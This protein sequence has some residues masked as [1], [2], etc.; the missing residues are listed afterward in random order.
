MRLGALFLGGWSLLLASCSGGGKPGAGGDAGTVTTGGAGT[1]GGASQG[2]ASQ[3]GESQGGMG[4][5]SGGSAGDGGTAGSGGGNV[6]GTVTGVVKTELGSWNEN[7][8]IAIGAA[9]TYTDAD[10]RFEIPDVPPEYDLVLIVPT[11]SYALVIRGIS[12][13]TLHLTAPGYENGHVANLAGVAT[14]GVGTPIPDDCYAR[15][16]FQDPDNRSA[17]LFGPYGLLAASDASYAM[18]LHWVGASSV[19]GRLYALQNRVDAE[20]RPISFDGFGWTPLEVSRG[21]MY[22]KR[23]GS[24]PATTIALEPVASRTVSGTVTVPPGFAPRLDFSIGPFDLHPTFRIDEEDETRGTYSVLLPTGIEALPLSAH[25]GGV[26]MDLD[27]GSSH[28]TY[29]LDDSQMT[30]DLASPAPPVSMLPAAAATGVDYDTR[31]GWEP[32]ADSV[33]T[34]WLNFERWRVQVVTNAS[35]TTIPDLTEYGVSHAAGSQGSWSVWSA[36]G[37]TT[38][39]EWL[40]S[41]APGAARPRKISGAMSSS[42]TFTLAN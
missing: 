36:I 9:T 2:G 24:D 8:I 26:S 38:V 30:V 42:R 19:S 40:T 29:F 17:A 25:I 34:V 10:G 41:L 22:G 7:A 1:Q 32:P 3:G 5:R 18:D 12:V 14:G 13:R 21:G 37:P 4:A 35:S 33:A 6:P 31:F 11:E 27:G 23:D 20:Y 15:V 28:T 39:D 16:A